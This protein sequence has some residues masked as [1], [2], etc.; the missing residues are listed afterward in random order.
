[1]KDITE[2]MKNQMYNMNTDKRPSILEILK[3]VFSVNQKVTEA[4]V[5]GDLGRLKQSSRNF[6]PSNI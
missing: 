1:M 2:H 5:L 3:S 4:D 6:L